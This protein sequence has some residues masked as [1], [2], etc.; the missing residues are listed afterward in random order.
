MLATLSQHALVTGFSD[1]HHTSDPRTLDRT[2]VQNRE[3]AA[4]HSKNR[5]STRA[6]RILTST[7][8]RYRTELHLWRTNEEGHS[9]LKES[10]WSSA[11]LA[12]QR[13]DGYSAERKTDSKRVE[14]QEAQKAQMKRS[15]NGPLHFVLLVSFS[16]PVYF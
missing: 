11:L 3:A 6:I 10:S 1:R 4:P 5:E 12:T 9:V 15:S 16:G 8:G 7:A 2:R 13:R 14:P